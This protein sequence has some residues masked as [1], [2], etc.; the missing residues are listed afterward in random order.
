M[1]LKVYSKELEKL[2]ADWVSNCIYE[3]P[4]AEKYPEYGNSGQNLALS[5][6][7][8]R[9]LVRM[10]TGWWEEVKDYNYDTNTCAP[11]KACGHYTQVSK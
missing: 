7:S 11:G 6:G 1:F 3:H 9:N 5:G 2:A 8:G 10:A 4:D